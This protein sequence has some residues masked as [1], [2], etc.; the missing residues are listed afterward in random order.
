MDLEF[1]ESMQEKEL[2]NE[3]IKKQIDCIYQEN[4]R[5]EQLLEPAEIEEGVKILRQLKRND[6]ELDRLTL[7]CPYVM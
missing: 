2:M 7:K 4:L 5:L 1:Q 6:A 3:E